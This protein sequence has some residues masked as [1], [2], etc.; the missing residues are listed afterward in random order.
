MVTVI[1]RQGEQMIIAGIDVKVVKKNI[2]NIYLSVLPPD[3]K[4]QV[5]AP[6]TVGDEAIRSFVMGHLTWIK[7]KKKKFNSQLRPRKRE[8]VSGETHYLFGQPYQMEKRIRNGKAGVGIEG[9]QLLL[10]V[11]QRS[12]PEQR[13]RVLTEWYRQQLNLKLEALVPKWESIIG[14]Q[15]NQIRTKNM[16]TKWGTCNIQAKRI[17]INLQ[18]AKKPINCLEYVV[19][20][21]LVHLLESSHNERFRT[22][23]DGFLPNWK[24][25]QKELNEFIIDDYEKSVVD[26]RREPFK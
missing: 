7:H 18:L 12:T 14:V 17:W 15:P 24:Q 3:G 10:Y 25:R 8:Y 1:I 2:K 20:H 5:S 9:T 13:K 4:V 16:K 22:Y 26:T 23:M 11:P 19:V 21:E 6:K